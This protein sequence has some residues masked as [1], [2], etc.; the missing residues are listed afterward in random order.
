MKRHRAAPLWLVA[1]VAVALVACQSQEVS[2]GPLEDLVGSWQFDLAFAEG[3]RQLECYAP[4]LERLADVAVEF[5]AEGHTDD[6]LPNVLGA[7][8]DGLASPQVPEI[9]R[10]GTTLAALELTTSDS[11]SMRWSAEERRGR[12]DLWIGPDESLE[13]R[14][15]VRVVPQDDRSLIV[16]LREPTPDGE[17][18]LR[19]LPQGSERAALLLD[20]A[21][22]WTRQH[23]AGWFCATRHDPDATDLPRY[24]HAGQIPSGT[25]LIRVSRDGVYLEGERVVPINGAQIPASARVSATSP[26]V[27]D[28][29][30]AIEDALH[31]APA[32]LPATVTL[33]ADQ[34]TPYVTLTE[35]M[36][37]A[38]AA[39][40]Q[41][42]ELA[43]R[44][45]G[46]LRA[47]P[48][49]SPRN[50]QSTI[51]TIDPTRLGRAMDEA[52]AQSGALNRIF[53]GN[54]LMTGI[55][56]DFATAGEGDAFVVGRGSGGLGMRGT[57][58]GGGGEGF[59]RVH[60]VGTIDTG[61][62]RGVSANMGRR[63][64]PAPRARVERGR[65]SVEGVLSR[66]Q[67]ERVVRRHSRGI[68]YCYERELQDNAELEGAIVVNFTIDLDGQVGSRSIE[69]DSMGNRTIQSCLLREFGRMRFPEPDGGVVVVSYP[70]TFRGVTE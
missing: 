49:F 14:Y 59:G 65:A 43:V 58:R 20:P 31:E 67:I 66:E 54:D 5:D 11:R 55:G 12:I 62:G 18:S 45:N 50:A 53:E 24:G 60:G 44:N 21:E 63:G 17:I 42:F 61:G 35:V 13:E 10:I 68:R 39:G 70:L 2:H 33:A 7:L 6:T 46:R 32:G 30:A 52:I 47:L 34:A 64:Q 29:Q 57:G 27:P 3:I 36:M 56:S 1:P 9:D 37:T 8:A 69:S 15:E 26:I 22:P 4:A 23:E 40:V 28:L 19:L 16:T 48:I 38:S 51:G 25:L 41:H